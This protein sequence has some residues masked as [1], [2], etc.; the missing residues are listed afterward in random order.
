MNV[1]DSITFCQLTI[2]HNHGGSKKGLTLGLSERRRVTQVKHRYDTIE[3][4]NV[5]LKAE[6]DQL[7]LAHK[8]K[9]KNAST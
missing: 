6:S 8:T 1:S 5:H 2:G 9:T 3:E 7:N 4:F